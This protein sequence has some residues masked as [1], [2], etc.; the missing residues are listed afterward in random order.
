VRPLIPTPTSPWPTTTSAPTGP[1]LK[2]LSHE[3]DFKKM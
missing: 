1:Y 3:I 2:G